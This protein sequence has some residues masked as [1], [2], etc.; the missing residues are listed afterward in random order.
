MSILLLE[1]IHEDAHA[2]LEQDFQV[3]MG[4]TDFP[5]PNTIDLKTIQA[6]LTRGR[7]QI[8]AAMILA[9]PRLKVIARCGAGLDNLDLKA[10][11]H[12]DI[13]VVYA[14]GK[15]SFAVAE[16]TL[17]L[18]L[19][20]AR[21][22][23][24][25]SEEVSQGNWAIRSTYK[26]IELRGKTLGLIGLGSIGL[27]VATLAQAFG[28]HIIYW[29]RSPKS[30]DFPRLEF[31]DVL[32]QADFITLHTALNSE[33][34]HL[35]GPKQLQLIDPHA[36]LINTARGGLVDETAL[37]SSLNSDKL[38]GYATD[39][40]DSDPPE[41]THPFLNHPKILVTPHSAVLTD[42][43]Y[44][45]ICMSTAQNVAA[46]LHGKPVEDQSIYK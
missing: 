42:R 18:M 4:N 44:R 11:K 14:P 41:H 16:H 1:S 10:A 33:T 5:L 17:L 15:T 38:A 40:L 28:M 34:R 30:V 27:S 45:D 3:H 21:N 39:L 12:A 32:K 9:C 37:L 2:L 8:T 36:F 26:G 31:D 19:A 46:I 35:I 24:L 22:L 29:S 6:I 43:T 20:L 23:R 7:G 25:L 13:P